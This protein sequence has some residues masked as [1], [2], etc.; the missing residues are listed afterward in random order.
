M[1]APSRTLNVHAPWTSTLGSL[2]VK[3]ATAA[4]PAKTTCP[5][6]HKPQLNIYE[7]T[8]GGGA[9]HYCFGCKSAGDMIGLATAAWQCDI[10]ATIH[11][12]AGEGLPFPHETLTRERIEAYCRDHPNDLKTLL[13]FIAQAR[14][15]LVRSQSQELAR[16][17]THFRVHTNLSW[18]RW[19]HGPGLLFGAASAFDV[20][21]LYKPAFSRKTHGG[22]AHNER[23]FT[24]RGWGDVL[25]VPYYNTPGRP[26]GFLFV[27]R[28][29]QI[30]DFAFRP[31]RL[32]RAG[33]MEAGLA[34]LPALDR[35]GSDL[36]RHA[37]IFD[38]PFLALR[39]QIRHTASSDRLMPLLAFYDGPRGLTG[40][41]PYETIGLRPV[42]FGFRLTPQILHQAI[43]AHGL[44]SI[45]RLAETDRHSIDH[46]VRNNSPQAL[47]NRVVNAAVPWQK[48]LPTWAKA[49]IAS[50]VNDLMSQMDRYGLPVLEKLAELGEMFDRTM[51]L[52]RDKCSARVG[53]C[54][55]SVNDEQT[56]VTQSR[57]GDLG[58]APDLLM[59]AVMILDKTTADAAGVRY[60]GK[61]LFKG[62]AIP[63]DLPVAAFNNKIADHLQAIVTKAT[64]EILWISPSWAN[65]KLLAVATALHVFNS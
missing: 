61:L 32:G 17:R 54:T 5:L 26:C 43:Q 18:E 15:Y 53:R 59:N 36:G 47:L 64:G 25:M 10:P 65:R 40:A 52:K 55:V 29:C 31:S 37:V 33:C 63:L 42:F 9:W 46:Y 27:G 4:L 3:P 49:N 11:R 44:L 39:L 23:I 6:C 1:R 35:A 19:E 41:A 24:G 51:Y 13:A 12:L 38:D 16:L 22:A 58:K 50:T 2:G 30:Q 21:T 56:W 48:F 60:T 45:T 28:Q 14:S 57:R 8:I 34:C 62:H 7:D 20:E